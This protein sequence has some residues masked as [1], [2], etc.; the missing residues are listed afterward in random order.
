MKRK[1]P[2]DKKKPRNKRRK[3]S[4]EK[5]TRKLERTTKLAEYG[6]RNAKENK[7]RHKYKGEYLAK[8]NA[9]RNDKDAPENRLR[10]GHEQREANYKGSEKEEGISRVLSRFF[11]FSPRKIQNFF[12]NRRLILASVYN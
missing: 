9:R 2:S 12:N 11:S 1:R 7:K 4:R 6:E 5:R 3:A 8:R 10:R